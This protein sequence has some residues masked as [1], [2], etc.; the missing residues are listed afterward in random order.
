MRRAAAHRAG[1]CRR[2]RRAATPR[3]WIVTRNAQW[4][5]DDP[6]PNAVAQALVWGFGRAIAVEHPELWGGLI[7]LP[8]EPSAGEAGW[9]VDE[10]TASDGEDQVAYRRGERRVQRLVASSNPPAASVRFDAAASYLITGGVGGLGRHVAHWMIAGGA[11]DLVL[12]GL[13][14]RPALILR[15]SC[16]ATAFASRSSPPTQAIERRWKHSSPRLPREESR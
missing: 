6:A 10:L 13:H 12:T 1:Y 11:T 16:R 5:D 9:I 4:P 14:E 2:G 15:G 3:V 8:P 7:D